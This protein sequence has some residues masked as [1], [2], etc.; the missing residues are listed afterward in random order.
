MVLMLAGLRGIDNEM[1]KAAQIDALNGKVG[2]ISTKLDRMAQIDRPL[3]FVT[4]SDHAEFLGTITVCND[5]EAMGYESRQCMDYRTAQEFDATPEEVGISF[6]EVNGF[7]AFPPELAR[8]RTRPYVEAAGA[9]LAKQAPRAI[10][11]PATVDQLQS[12]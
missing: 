11:V 2:A 6:V 12:L 7:T 5:P 9:A 4:L 10:L 8:Y 1:I 3:D